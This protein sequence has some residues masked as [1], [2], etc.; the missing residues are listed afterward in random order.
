MCKPSCC[1]SNNGEGLGVLAIAAGV[2]VLVAAIARPVIRA[3]ESVLRLV[4]E[5]ALITAGVIAGIL[6]VTAAI[7]IIRR[8]RRM[9]HALPTADHAS[10]PYF[11]V[12]HARW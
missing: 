12:P 3:A 6:V 5:I 2:I 8:I 9:A 11:T 7:V 1:S 4:A 10:C